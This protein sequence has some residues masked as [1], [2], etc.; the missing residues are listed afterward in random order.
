MTESG[1][2]ESGA[3]R[4]RA[5]RAL[6]WRIEDALKRSD[7]PSSARL[8][9]LVLLTLAD[10]YTGVVPTERSPSYAELA[11]DTR[12][13][14]RTVF[15]MVGLLERHGWLVVTRPPQKKQ[16]T[17]HAPNGYTTKLPRVAEDAPGRLVQ[18]LHQ[19]GATT[20]PGLVQPLHQAGAAGTPA[21]VQPLHQAGATTALVVTDHTDPTDH[22]DRGRAA[23]ADERWRARDALVAD[24]ARLTGWPAVR[25]AA[26][27]AAWDRYPGG[28]RDVDSY[29]GAMVRD[30]R[31]D[32]LIGRLV[33][34]EGAAA[35][36]TPALPPLCGK[37]EGTEV[38]G[39]ASRLVPGTDNPCPACHPRGVGRAS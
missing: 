37:C 38:D 13:S 3:G 2:P 34:A 21:L 39:V 7:L 23:P 18:P 10:V 26:A 33:R 25:I 36:A 35:S 9:L 24:A 19:A 12:L 15:T 8:V 22:T 5:A 20:A 6:R 31:A 17:E 11:Q 27:L 28:T 30:G 16:R 4:P 14:R 29:A 32:A 1:P